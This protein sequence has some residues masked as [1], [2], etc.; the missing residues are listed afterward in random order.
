MDLFPLSPSAAG[1]PRDGALT[2]GTVRPAAGTDGPPVLEQAFFLAVVT[3]G[4]ARLAEGG[5]P[6]D[7]RPHDLLVLTPS[8]RAAFTETSPDFALA[9]LRIA[10]P[11]FDS[12]PDGEPL[13]HQLA[14]FAAHGRLPVVHL[15]GEDFNRM[16]TA[17][18]LF[19]YVPARPRAHERGVRRHLCS[20]CLLMATDLLAQASRTGSTCVRRPDE[21]YRRFRRL[22]VRHYRKEHAIAFYAD[23]LCISTTYLSRIVKQTTGRTVREHMARLLTAEARRLLDCTDWEVKQIAHELGF[24]DASAFGKFFRKETHASPRAFRRKHTTQPE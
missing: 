11:Y 5:A 22:L 21:L 20:A 12:L 24:A 16:R 19:R 14:G 9:Y 8:L 13:Y 4:G 23:R 10:P 1:E 6:R 3:G 18:E 17:L 7:L 15:G 2:F